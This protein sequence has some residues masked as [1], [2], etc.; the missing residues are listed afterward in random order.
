MPTFWSEGLGFSSS[1]SQYVASR[2]A[3]DPTRDED[4]REAILRHADAAEKEPYFVARA[5][6]KTQLDPIYDMSEST[7]DEES[8]QKKKKKGPLT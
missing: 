6:A 7:E 1:L 5:Y 2:T 3:Y 8:N 4:P